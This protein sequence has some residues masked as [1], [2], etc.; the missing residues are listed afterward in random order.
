MT[1]AKHVG[2]WLA[3]FL[4]FFV[5]CSVIF[6]ALPEVYLFNLYSESVGFITEQDW[7]DL[8]MFSILGASLLINA[9]LIYVIASIRR[10]PDSD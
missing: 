4:S 8:F 1:P 5:I 9:V 2:L 3:Q 7:N 10:K 6:V